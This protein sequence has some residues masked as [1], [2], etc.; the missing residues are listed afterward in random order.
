MY[1]V[2]S[3]FTTDSSCAVN[4]N[5]WGGE[6]NVYLWSCAGHMYITKVIQV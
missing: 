3:Q 1:K 4:V 6:I 2:T 5:V